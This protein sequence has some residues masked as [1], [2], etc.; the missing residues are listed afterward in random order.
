MYITYSELIKTLILDPIE[1]ANGESWVFKIEI[2][3]HSQKG[4]FAQLWRQDSYDIKPTF[5]I[6][7]D[8]IASETLFVQENYRLEMSHK[9]HY[10]VDVESCLS[11]ILTEL[12]KEFDLS[13]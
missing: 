3:R 6:K 9:P 2:L 7:P 10:F 1:F 4:Y 11:A 5:A 8:W 13:E 12:T